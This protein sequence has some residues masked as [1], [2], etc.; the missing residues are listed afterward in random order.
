MSTTI[1][2]EH[3]VYSFKV[4]YSDIDKGYHSLY[5]YLLMPC[6]CIAYHLENKPIIIIIII[7]GK[8]G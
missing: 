1:E 5:L 7:K 4:N 3:T 6:M 2:S 8:G